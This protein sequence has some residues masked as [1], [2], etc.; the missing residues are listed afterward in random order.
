MFMQRSKGIM[1]L[2]EF[3]EFLVASFDAVGIF[4]IVV[5][6]LFVYTLDKGKKGIGVFHILRLSALLVLRY[7]E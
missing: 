3:I 5:Q 2:M 4:G 7:S 1:E 6:R